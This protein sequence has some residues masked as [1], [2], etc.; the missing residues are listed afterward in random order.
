MQ[1]SH[2]IIIAI[3]CLLVGMGIGI[4]LAPVPDAD[5]DAAMILLRLQSEISASLEMLDNSMAAAAYD[6]GST[7][8]DNQAAHDILLE[9]S[10]IHPAIIDCTTVSPDGIILAAEPSIHHGEEGTDVSDQKATQ[11]ILATRRP[12]MS[13][14]VPVAEGGD[15][16][17]IS[18]PV[19]TRGGIASDPPGRFLGFTSIVFRPDI[20]IGGVAEPVVSKTPYSVTVVD[21]DGRVLYDTDPDQID[22]P[23]DDPIYSAYPVLIEFVTRVTE[24]RQGKGSYI[25]RDQTKEAV[26]TTVSLHGTEW[27]VA[28]TR[29]L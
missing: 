5:H 3:A 15:A 10:G 11:Q 16:S 1:S 22:L 2:A 21:T 18:A 19:F 29:T 27:R 25:F 23:L 4:A 24:E 8:L 14:I 7:G 9:T 28:V 12:I 26:W 20:L 17:F 13:G 6:L